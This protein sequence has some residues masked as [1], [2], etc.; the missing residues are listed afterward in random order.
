MLG[1]FRDTYHRQSKVSRRRGPRWSMCHRLG[2]CTLEQRGHMF[3][4]RVE[5]YVGH[6]SP[7]AFFCWLQ[8]LLFLSEDDRE[9]GM[10]VNWGGVSHTNLHFTEISP[11]W[12][13]CW[14][15]GRTKAGLGGLEK[16][17]QMHCLPRARIPPGTGVSSCPFYAPD[18][19]RRGD[20]YLVIREGRLGQ[21]VHIAQS[22]TSSKQWS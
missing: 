7:E 11:A 20:L 3:E 18:S 1:A 22:F 10:G 14:G 15:K 4:M 19:S 21:G 2:V 17:T 16:G 13:G 6:R 5:G 12:R 8:N 9:Q